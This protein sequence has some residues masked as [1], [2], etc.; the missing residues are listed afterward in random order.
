MGTLKD[1]AKAYE[2]KKTLNIAD[3]DKFDINEPVEQKTAEDAEG[4]EFTYYALIRDEQ[5]YRI[6]NG[7][8][9]SI[10]NM[11][12][13]YS[14]KGQELKQLSV[15]KTGSGMQTKYTVVPVV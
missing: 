9:N 8:M 12:D 14:D 11:I 2:P 3:L 10:K 15:T 6:P 7:V 5:E 4:A 13:A 1:E